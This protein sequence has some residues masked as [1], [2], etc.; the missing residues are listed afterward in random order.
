MKPWFRAEISIGP[1][2]RRGKG[3]DRY[4]NLKSDS[5]SIEE[6]NT[7]SDCFSSLKTKE[8]KFLIQ[9]CRDLTGDAAIVVDW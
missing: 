6:K 4:K 8:S 3:D 7:A 9:P 1:G 5:S 2:D